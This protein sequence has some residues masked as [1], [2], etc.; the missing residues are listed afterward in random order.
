MVVLVAALGMAVPFSGAFTGG[1]AVD[2]FLIVL[3][4]S[5]PLTSVNRISD[6]TLNNSWQLVES[7]RLTGKL[8]VIGVKILVLF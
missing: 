6:N 3:V 2:I 7:M 4:K 5:R 1:L 8:N